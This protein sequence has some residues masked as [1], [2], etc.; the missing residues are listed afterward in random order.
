MNKTWK[1]NRAS[2]FAVRTIGY[3]AR[4]PEALVAAETPVVRTPISP[5]QPADEAAVTAV[6]T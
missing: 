1:V 3:L 6:L 4:N 5:V 2:T